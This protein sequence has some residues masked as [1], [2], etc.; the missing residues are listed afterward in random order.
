MSDAAFDDEALRAALLSRM[1]AAKSALEDRIQRRL[2]GKGLQKR[3][4]HL[5]ASIETGVDD[6]GDAVSLSAS[7]LGVAYAAIHEFGGKTAA[8][9]IVAVK[10]RALALKGSGAAFAKIARHPGS[11]FPS[12]SFLAL[13]FKEASTELA[14]DLRQAALESLRD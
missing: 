8:H 14:T 11:V 9:E 2:S 1:Q 12:R 5:A 10:S 6:D 4:G 13:S 3:S 7:S